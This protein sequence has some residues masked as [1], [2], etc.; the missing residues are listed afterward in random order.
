MKQSKQTIPHFYVTSSVDMTEI[1]KQ[2]KEFNQTL[3]NPDQE[4]VSVTDLIIKAS[5]LAFIDTP[6][7][8]S[9][10]HDDENIV[11]WE[12]LNIGIAVAVDSELVVPVIEK[13]D[14]LSITEISLARQMLVNKAKEGKQSSLAPGRFTISNLGM[15]QIDQFSAIINPPESAILAVSSILKRPV[16]L[17]DDQVGLR[18]MLTLT[19]SIDHRIVDGLLACRFINT[20]KTLLESPEKIFG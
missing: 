2:R 8:N 12:D 3:T 16:A 10:I 4:S 5:A 7:L 20:I 14:K 9:S 17:D 18:D 11:L 13:V 1:L 6:E 15:F 19:L